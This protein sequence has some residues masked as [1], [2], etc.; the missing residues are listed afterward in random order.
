ME[1]WSPEK[2]ARRLL[3]YLQHPKKV[4]D[5]Q[6]RKLYYTVRDRDEVLEQ[7][8]IQSHQFAY[9]YPLFEDADQEQRMRLLVVLYV[10]GESCISANLLAK[11][12]R[13]WKFVV[14]LFEDELPTVRNKDGSE[15]CNEWHAQLIMYLIPYTNKQTWKFAVE[16][17]IL[18]HLLAKMQKK[19]RTCNTQLTFQI[20]RSVLARPITQVSMDTMVS[21]GLFTLLEQQ[22]QKSGNLLKGTPPCSDCNHSIDQQILS[23]YTSN[24]LGVLKKKTKI[25]FCF[26]IFK[27]IFFSISLFFFFLLCFFL[28]SCFKIVLLLCLYE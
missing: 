10:C 4:N 21:G 11:E 20:I 2:L 7:L 22:T 3:K 9:I 27:I 13:V 25:H 14:A 28:F 6:F 16:Y 5:T 1:S 12:K 8:R 19:P 15:K 17:G 24:F 23:V 18:N 26:F